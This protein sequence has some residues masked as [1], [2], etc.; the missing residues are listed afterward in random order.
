MRQIYVAQFLEGF[1]EAQSAATDCKHGAIHP[2]HRTLLVIVKDQL[3]Q[4]VISTYAQN[5]KP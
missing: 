1:A 4:L 3:S 5:N 2:R